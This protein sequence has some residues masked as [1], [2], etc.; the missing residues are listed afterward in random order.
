[1][2]LQQADLLPTAPQR[3]AAVF[4]LFEMYKNESVTMNPFASIFVH[5]LV[6]I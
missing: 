2:L 5:A 6:K 3:L 1:M 4:M